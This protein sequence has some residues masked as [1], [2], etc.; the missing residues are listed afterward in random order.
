MIKRMNT[1]IPGFDK[2][3]EGG[4]VS[5]SVNLL[6]GGTGT[7]KTI[8]CLQFLYYG[9]KELNEKG[10]YISFEESEEELKADAAEIGFNFEALS[11]KVKFVY[12]P[13]YNITNFLN[14]LKE[15][16]LI[17]D[18]KRVV[19]DSMSAL[20]MPMEDDFERRKQI[21]K[22]REALKSLNC[23]SILVSEVPAEGSDSGLAARFSRFDVEEFLCDSV[24]VLYYAG[25]GGESD[26]AIRVIKMRRTAHKREPIPMEIGKLGIR[27]L[28]GK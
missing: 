8:F 7:G 18:P 23:T 1:G 26:R 4:L 24:I 16:I 27:V 15:E 14:V 11:G 9:A 5:N 13:P 20:A 6:S 10:V 21:F 3:V 2:V 22:I 12:I 25:I 28:S 17:F 19:I